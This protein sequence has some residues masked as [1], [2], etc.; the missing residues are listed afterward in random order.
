VL[1]VLHLSG[2]MLLRQIHTT[3]AYWSLILVAAHIGLHWE[4]I[5][6]VVQKMTGFTGVSRIRSSILRVSTVLLII[7]GL[8]AFWD[9]DMAAKLFQGHS[10]DFWN[11]ESP[12]ILFFTSNLA[13][14]GL[15]VVGTR[16][17]FKL[18]MKF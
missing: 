15:Y 18:M 16:S 7:Y 14:L 2:G 3:T 13:L 4:I 6:S 11:P 8:W 5:S 9:R 17:L 10:F 1:A 12:A